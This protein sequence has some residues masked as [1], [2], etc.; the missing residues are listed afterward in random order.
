VERRY[1]DNLNNQIEALRRT[2]PT[3]QDAHLHHGN[4]GDDDPPGGGGGGGPRMPSKA[5]IIATAAAHIQEM[6]RE[7][8]RLRDANRALHEQVASLQKLLLLRGGGGGGG[9]GG[10]EEPHLLQYINAL[11]V[12]AAGQLPPTPL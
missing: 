7:H 3:L 10:G 9:G 8:T 6:Q 4:D 1:R 12:M 11:R 5:V 2:L